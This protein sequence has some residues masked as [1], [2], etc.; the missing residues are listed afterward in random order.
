MWRTF[1]VLPLFISFFLQY[2]NLFCCLA[3]IRCFVIR[4][5]CSSSISILRCDAS[6]MASSPSLHGTPNSPASRPGDCKTPE[7]PTKRQRL[8]DSAQ[9][10]KKEVALQLALER[11]RSI[12]GMMADAKNRRPAVWER[13]SWP[14]CVDC[15][16]DVASFEME[17]YKHPSPFY[18]YT[19]LC[20]KCA[21]VKFLQMPE[22]LVALNVW[23]H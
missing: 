17:F 23:H 4:L 3:H 7:R 8:E 18:M 14:D 19:R 6:H 13:S 12:A 9:A 21:C 10:R 5:S 15:G 16:N 22:K 1:F 11:Q 2:T 20:Y